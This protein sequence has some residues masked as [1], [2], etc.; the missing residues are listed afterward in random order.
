[1]IELLNKVYAIAVEGLNWIN[2]D[3]LVSVMKSVMLS[4]LSLSASRKIFK[5]TT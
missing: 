4:N 1:M 5:H 3:V 2:N